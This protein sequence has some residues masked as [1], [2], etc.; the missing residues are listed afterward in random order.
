L[1]TT[2]VDTSRQGTW[3]DFFNYNPATRHRLRLL[4]K[5]IPE[6]P[7][8][9][10]LDVG[11]GDGSLL[12]LV[13]AV[14]DCD[15]YGADK[16]R[17]PAADALEFASFY[18][19]DIEREPPPGRY[20]LVLCTEVLEHLEDASAAL[21]N[22]ASVCDGRLIATVP[23]GS[24]GPTD[25]QM[26]HLR[27]YDAAEF[28]RILEEAGFSI[29]HLF[30]WG[31]PFHSLY[32]RLLAQAPDAIM[33][34]FGRPAYG[35]FQKVLCHLLYGLVFLNSYRF[36]RQLIAVAAPRSDASTS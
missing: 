22:M 6:T 4:A 26:G 1:A 13:K 34:G 30:R 32:K 9:S 8:R 20:D 23:S 12:R 7:F 2:P 10:V 3:S 5:L 16:I 17:T 11:C 18:C 15:A 35:P 28:K 21:R 25:R 14:A 27:H 24:L 33:K 19:L 36:G 31:W 29:L